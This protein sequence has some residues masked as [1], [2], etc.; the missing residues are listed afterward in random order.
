VS[1]LVPYSKATELKFE[2]RKHFNRQFKKTV[3]AQV[4][5]ETS[6]HMMLVIFLNVAIA[7]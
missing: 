2:L 6:F 3:L 5:L 1:N 7:F 4:I